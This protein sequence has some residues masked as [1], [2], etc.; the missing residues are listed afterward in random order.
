MKNIRIT[1]GVLRVIGE[2]PERERASAFAY[3]LDCVN[4]ADTDA[5]RYP[6]LTAQMMAEDATAEEIRRIVE[7]LNERCG[8]SFRATGEKTKQLIRARYRQGYTEADFHAVIN[9]KADEWTGTELERYLRPETLFGTRFESY[10]QFARKAK[11]ER[12]VSFDSNEFFTAAL[13]RSY[14]GEKW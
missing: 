14:G 12:A 10:L 5:E 2:I 1:D 13:A 6:E 4:G 7:H 11:T 8:T 9:S 3:V